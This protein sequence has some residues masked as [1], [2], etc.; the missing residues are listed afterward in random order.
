MKVDLTNRVAIVFG[1]GCVAENVEIGWGNGQAAA[2]GY[3]RA[4]AQV[5]CVDIHLHRAELTA[6]L[7]RG[8]GGAAVA[9]AADVASSN[10]VKAAIDR[11]VSEF[12]TVHIVHNNAAISPFGDPVTL[13][14]ADWDRT[15]AVNVKSCFLACKY[16]LPLMRAQRRGV[17]TNISS[18]LSARISEY[19]VFSYYA[20]KA[21][22]DQFSRAVAVANAPYGIRCNSVQPGLMNTPLIHAHDDVLDVHGSAEKT[23]AARDAMSPTGKQGTAWDIA[24]LSVFLASDQAAYLNGVV[25]P[26]DGGLMAKQAAQPHPLPE[27]L[28]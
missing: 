3:A 5:V 24:N 20:S 22:V 4:G 6:E 27:D 2:V 23:I 1:A 17:I 15:F 28:Q 11:A 21:A 7:I 26:V 9:V 10:D 18:I 13:D 8:E 14:E 25:V 12:E 19:D 16:T